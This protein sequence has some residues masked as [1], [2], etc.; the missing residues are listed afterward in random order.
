VWADALMA[1]DTLPEHLVEQNKTS[2]HFQHYAL[3]DPALLV[4]PGD[5]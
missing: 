3:P 1:V 5:D 2:P 4:T